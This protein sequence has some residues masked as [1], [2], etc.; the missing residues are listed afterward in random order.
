[1]GFEITTYATVG[2]NVRIEVDLPQF[3][4]GERVEMVVRTENAKRG[5]YGAL[6]GGLIH[7]SGDFDAPIDEFAEYS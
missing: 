1:M 5:G 2:E 4:K 3:P 7:M 6:K